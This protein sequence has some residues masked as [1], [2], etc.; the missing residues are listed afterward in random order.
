MQC[1]KLLLIKKGLDSAAFFIASY[2]LEGFLSV[3]V[4]HLVTQY[5]RLRHYKFY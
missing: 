5:N 1:K 4:H 3:C 2:L